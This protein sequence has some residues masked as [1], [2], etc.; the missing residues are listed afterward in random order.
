MCL[1]GTNGFGYG[2]KPPRDWEMSNRRQGA[3]EGVKPQR[4]DARSTE[5][6]LRGRRLWENRNDIE[7]AD[8]G[9]N[10]ILSILSFLS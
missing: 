6:V 5:N 4:E 1:V 3:E 9:M 8:V 2:N 10:F 7:F